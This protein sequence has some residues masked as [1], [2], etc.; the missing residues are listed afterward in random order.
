MN[1]K[2]HID[3][4]FQEKLKDFQASPSDAVWE[5]ISSKLHHHE[6]EKKIIPLWLRLSAIA[7]ALLLLVAVGS[8]VLGGD[9]TPAGNTIVDT[10]DSIDNSP[11]AQENQNVVDQDSQLDLSKDLN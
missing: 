3:R 10:E 5:N 2:K 11:N 9:E 7:A 4:L 8:I 1:D 6:K